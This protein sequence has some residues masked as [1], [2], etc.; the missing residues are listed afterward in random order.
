MTLVLWL[1]YA[2]YVLLRVFAGDTETVARHAAVLGIIGL[3]DIPIL[4]IAIRLCF[5][6]HPKPYQLPP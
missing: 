1:I 4:Y 3:I 2:A 5:G 6:I